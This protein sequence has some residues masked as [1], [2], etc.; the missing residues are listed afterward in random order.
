MSITPINECQA[1]PDEATAL[2]DFLR[3]VIARILDAPG[4]RS[5]E[6]LV[7]HDD[8]TCGAIIEVWDRVVAHQASVSRI[9][10]D[11]LQQAPSSVAVPVRAPTT[12]GCPMR[13]PDINVEVQH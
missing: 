11:L 10:P 3:S 12:I 4:C 5:C 2:R 6:R 9:P 8:P 13:P 7:Q 1:H